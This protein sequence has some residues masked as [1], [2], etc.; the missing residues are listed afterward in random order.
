MGES[1]VV[2]VGGAV[3]RGVVSATMGV[4]DGAGAVV[5]D[6]GDL[7]HEQRS[8]SLTKVRKPTN[9][10]FMIRTMVHPQSRIK[11][12]TGCQLN[13]PGPRQNRPDARPAPPHRP[14]RLTMLLAHLKRVWYNVAVRLGFSYTILNCVLGEQMPQS[15]RD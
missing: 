9:R 7:E 4:A 12:K 2:G 5:S 15:A 8:K 10:F 11:P 13:P 1:V 3:G 6:S 14:E